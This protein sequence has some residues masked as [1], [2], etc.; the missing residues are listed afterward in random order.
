[1]MPLTA[2]R[3]PLPS[4]SPTAERR[5]SCVLLLVDGDRPPGPAVGRLAPLLDGQPVICVGVWRSIAAA[6]GLGRAAL[7]ERIV[8]AGVARLDAERRGAVE[9]RVR[10]AASVLA[11]RGIAAA[12]HVLDADGDGTAELA[13][14]AQRQ[15]AHAVLLERPSWR[16]EQ[17][18]RRCGIA[19]LVAGR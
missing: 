18:L 12:A 1:M 13:A 5:S 9:Q 11:E 15:P 2:T 17:R 6:A 8:R 7:P 4:A 19:V 16:L 3:T 14:L 10:D